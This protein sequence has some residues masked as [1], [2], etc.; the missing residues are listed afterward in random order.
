[1]EKILVIDDEINIRESIKDFLEYHNY[2][3][4]M[5]GS[6]EEGVQTAIEIKPALILCDVNMGG[7]SGYEVLTALR[8]KPEVANI[9]FV[10]LTAKATMQDLREGM[11]LGADDY[12]TKPFDLNELLRCVNA[13]LAK[14]ESRL[15]SIEEKNALLEQQRAKLD[16]LNYL[17]SHE[18]RAGI[19]RIMSL[20][21][22]IKND[23]EV[24]RQM[25]VATLNDSLEQIGDV[26]QEIDKLIKKDD[27]SRESPVAASKAVETVALVD[28]DEIACM[29][30]TMIIKN[31]APGMNVTTF[32]SPEKYLEEV[33]TGRY[34]PD[35]TLLDINM[36]VMNGFGVLDELLAMGYSSRVIMLSSSISP[37]E[38]DKAKNHPITEGYEMKPLTVE[39][40]VNI[41][42]LEV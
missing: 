23:I 41:L 25:I 36:P 21:E 32:T 17:N 15:N 27:A 29:L 14:G 16:Q 30:N 22:T 6:G 2:E 26:L 5:A 12:L 42:K 33:K 7:I 39:K 19:S 4:Y 1:M 37:D 3:V 24:D 34:L 20:H 8:E 13:G 11:N 10:F 35:L 38:I 40:V 28:D 9:P 31:G 18:L